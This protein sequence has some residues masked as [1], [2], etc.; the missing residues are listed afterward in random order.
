MDTMQTR[1]APHSLS[2]IGRILHAS[3]VLGHEAWGPGGRERV[4]SPDIGGKL[5]EDLVNFFQLLTDRRVPYLTVGGMAMLAHVRSWNTAD[6]DVIMSA[7][8]LDEI[9][10]LFIDELDGDSAKCRFESLRVNV[11]FTV[12]P[13][14][15]SVADN[16]RV[17]YRFLDLD[18][19]FAT[20]DG[21]ILF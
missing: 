15:R 2:D 3:R 8:T 6:I 1:T 14:L 13:L 5:G 18:V 17:V 20:A 10:E 21:L 4:L 9:S 7:V 16:H 12:D 11:R 19:P